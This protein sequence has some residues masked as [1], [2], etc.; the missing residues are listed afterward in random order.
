MN[1]IQEAKKFALKE[2]EKFGL[3]TPIHFEISEKKALELTEKLNANKTITLI[4]VYLMDVKLGE[5][6]TQNKNPEHVK[7]SVEA[8]KEFLEKF[9]LDE[10]TKKKIINCLEAHHG[11]VPFICKEAEI[12]ANADCY[13]FIHPKGFFAFLTVLGKR[14]LNFNEILNFAELKLDE[15]YKILSLEICKEELEKYYHQ[16]KEFIKIAREL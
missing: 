13:R 5:A 6:S 11:Q 8:A 3:P 12:C 4:G 10:E 9:N 14:N 16:F 15:K 7:M 2:I 1:I